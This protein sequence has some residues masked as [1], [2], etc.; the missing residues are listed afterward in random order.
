M[1]FL[2][3]IAWI[4]FLSEVLSTRITFV[5]LLLFMNI[6][7]MG[8]HAF[9]TTKSYSTKFAIVA[10]FLII[11]NMLRQFLLRTEDSVAYIALKVF[12]FTMNALN[13]MIF[14]LIG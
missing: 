4:S 14:V 7:L 3:V 13:K 11:F 6:L 1:N 8:S 10:F 2:N 12:R 9:I 5:F